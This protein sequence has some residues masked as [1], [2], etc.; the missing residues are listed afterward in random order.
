MVRVSVLNDAL[1]SMYNAEKGKA[2]DYDQTFLKSYCQYVDDHRSGKIV[3]E[4][5]GTIELIDLKVRYKE[6]LPPRVWRGPRISST[7]HR[8]IW[9]KERK[10]KKEEGENPERITPVICR[11]LLT[12][13]FQQ[14]G[15]KCTS[16]PHSHS[17]HFAT[18]HTPPNASF[19]FFFFDLTHLKYEFQN[20]F[21]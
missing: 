10:H 17:G 16:K 7:A 15:L 19:F 12:N 4:L 11:G 13:L 9:D 1:K 18:H 8:P 21:P 6:S 2:T 3:V 5:N 20:R 14:C